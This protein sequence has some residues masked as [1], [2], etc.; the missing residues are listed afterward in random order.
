LLTAAAKDFSVAWL[1]DR[2]FLSFFD[3]VVSN[4]R[5]KS[6]LAETTLS[7]QWFPKQ[8]N[9]VLKRLRDTAGDGERKAARL[10]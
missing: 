10:H 9:A 1:A 8:H 5:P 3:Y 7:P 6:F 4:A 2:F